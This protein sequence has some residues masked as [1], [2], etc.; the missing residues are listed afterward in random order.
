MGNGPIEPAADMRVF[1]SAMWQMF[2]A[3]VLEGFNEHQALTIMGGVVAEGIRNNKR[4]E[5]D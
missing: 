4:E 1:A 3:L 5:D 2:N